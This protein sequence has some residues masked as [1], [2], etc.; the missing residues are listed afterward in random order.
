LFKINKYFILIT[1]N[2]DYSI[3]YDILTNAEFNKIINYKYLIKWYSHNLIIEN[4]Y[5]K[6]YPIPLGL[7]YHTIYNN[8]SHEWSKND[9]E[10]LPINQEKIMINIYNKSKFFMK[11]YIIRLIF[12]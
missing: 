7:D 8:I 4:N 9:E 11:E 1:G 10:I 6:I 5:N 3:P 12:Y 2:S